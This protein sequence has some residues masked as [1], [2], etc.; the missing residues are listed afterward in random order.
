LLAGLLVSSL[1]LFATDLP[2]VRQPGDPALTGDDRAALA[3]AWTAVEPLL[4]PGYDL[5]QVVRTSGRQWAELDFVQF[6]AGVL[7]SAGYTVALATGPWQGT[8]RTWILVGVPVSAAAG[9]MAYIPV[10]GAPAYL[11]ARSLIG[12]VAWQGGIVGSTFDARYMTFT[13][14]TPVGY[15]MVPAVRVSVPL[16]YGVVNDTTTL[17]ISGTDPDGQILFCYWRLSD[18]TVLAD[19]RL[20][21]WHRFR[22]IGLAQATVSVYDTRGG[23]TDLVFPVDV[24]AEKPDCGCHKP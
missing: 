12:Q 13:A 4:K 22:T 2:V 10:E 20:T 17:Q 18:G 8:T 3:A 7:Q 19:S 1:S 21:I 9:G 14:A 24:L 23:R 6:T 15:N 5:A 11:G 16:G